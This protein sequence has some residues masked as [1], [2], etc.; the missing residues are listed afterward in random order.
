MDLEGLTNKQLSELERLANEL[1]TA[2]R[3]A[4]LHEEPLFELL[5]GLKIKTSEL[6]RARYDATNSEYHGY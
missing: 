4:K 2:M 1:E 6:R 5:Q 3:K